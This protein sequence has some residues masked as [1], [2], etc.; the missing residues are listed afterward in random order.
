LGYARA[1]FLTVQSTFGYVSSQFS[2]G[3]VLCGGGEAKLNQCVTSNEAACSSGDAAGV[4]CD[5][6][7]MTGRYPNDSSVETIEQN[8]LNLD[9]DLKVLIYAT[10]ALNITIPN[11]L[12]LCVC[13][14]A[15]CNNIRLNP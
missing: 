13:V 7:N 1:I 2:F 10:T 3:E 11:V 4:V 15:G 8:I 5:D 12:I 9:T 14:Y 6:G